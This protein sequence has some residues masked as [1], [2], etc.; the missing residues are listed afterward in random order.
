MPYAYPYPPPNHGHA[1]GCSQIIANYGVLF[2]VQSN[3]GCSDA[4]TFQE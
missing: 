2:E 4:Q 3:N 1:T